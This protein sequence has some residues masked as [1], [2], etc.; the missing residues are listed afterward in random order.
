MWKHVRSSVEDEATPQNTKGVSQR[1]AA[2]GVPLKIKIYFTAPC[3][4]PLMIHFCA[5]R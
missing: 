1:L 3:V 5:N 4:T 2:T